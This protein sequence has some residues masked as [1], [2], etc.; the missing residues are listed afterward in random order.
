MTLFAFIWIVF[1]KICSAIGL[2]ILAQ[3]FVCFVI[4][5]FSKKKFSDILLDYI[6]FIL[7][8]LIQILEK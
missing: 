6:E 4:S 8:K 2:A 1:V 7:T 3:I 5:I